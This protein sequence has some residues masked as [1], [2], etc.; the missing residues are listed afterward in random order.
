M[1]DPRTST[2]RTLFDD[3]AAR[4]PD[5]PYLIRPETGRTWSYAE[6]RA[7]IMAAA[8][9]L[10]ERLGLRPGDRVGIVMT[11]RPELVFTWL[12]AMALGAIAVPVNFSLRPR[13]IAYILANCE[14]SAA[15]VEDRF[16][17][18]FAEAMPDLPALRTVSLLRASRSFDGGEDYPVLAPA[19]VPFEDILAGGGTGWPAPAP[20][21]DAAGLIIYTS[22]TTGNPK[23]A[24]L[25]HR[26]LIT[27]ASEIAAWHSFTPADRSML[28][29]PLF[30]VNGLTLTLLT[31]AYTGASVVLPERFHASRFWQDVARHRVVWF[32]GAP[33][34]LSILLNSPPPSE[35]DVSS[36]EFCL[37]GTAPLPVE[38]FRQ[39]EE[40]FGVYIIEGYGMTETSCRSTFNPHP[41]GRITPGRD[42]GYRKIGSVGLPVGNELRIVDDCN[43]DVPAGTPG[44]IL[45]RG[46]NV[47]DRYWADDEATR[48]AFTDDWFHSGDIGVR[49]ADGYY[50]IVDRK[51]DLIIRGGENISPR[52]VDEVLYQ[53]PAV[54]EAATVGAPH[55][56]Y[57]EEVLSYVALKSGVEATPAELIAFCEA[58]LAHFKCP[59]RILVLD[60]LP[61]GPTGKLLRR[62]LR[63][64]ARREASSAEHR[65][66]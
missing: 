66:R 48:A 17:D 59:K 36:L 16:W 57:G 33:T 39:F 44:E 51:K 9:G 34:I 41:R 14:A 61:K 54:R 47:M 3:R 35:L 53:H 46:A 1:L 65:V 27:N 30:H 23:G 64:R 25:S 49:D 4:Q 40:R 10:R 37:C 20:A 8:T 50:F 56:T 38:L 29:L 63:D 13:E 7:A 2:V 60:D 45:I 58:R 24:V 26:N 52:E 12:G 32:S 22:G 18:Q 6:A 62:E 19:A 5:A 31:S 42:D 28:L 21:P 11:T 15:V 43:E 55:P